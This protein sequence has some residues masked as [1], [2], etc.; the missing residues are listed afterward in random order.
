ML[1]FGLSSAPWLFTTVMGH[2]VKFKFLRFLGNDLIGYL[3]DLIFAA[4]S[5]R[6]AVASAQQMISP[7]S[8]ADDQS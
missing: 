7:S 3:D 4:G 2:S 5:A 6:E 1:S 8:P